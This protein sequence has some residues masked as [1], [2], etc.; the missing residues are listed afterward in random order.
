M[1]TEEQVRTATQL[2]G[3][4]VPL[5]AICRA[6]GVT[7]DTFQGRRSDQLSGLPRRGRGGGKKPRSAPPTPEEIDERCREIREGWSEEERLERI[8]GPAKLQVFD[9]G[10]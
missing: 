7:R 6:V 3:D 5:D 4:G 10:D 2:W 9:F 8:V 1:L